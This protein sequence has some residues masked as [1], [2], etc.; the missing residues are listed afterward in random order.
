MELRI[1]IVM[2][3]LPY[4]K[5]H[6]AFLVIYGATV[7]KF[8]FSYTFD[9]PLQSVQ[10]KFIQYNQY[11]IFKKFNRMTRWVIACN[12]YCINISFVFLKHMIME[13]AVKYKSFNM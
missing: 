1:E 6:D 5:V 3:K 12:W 13:I 8:V 11:I 4:R 7:W 2:L 9:I 10:Y